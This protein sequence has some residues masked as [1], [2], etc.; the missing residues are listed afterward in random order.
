MFRQ[1]IK[2]IENHKKMVWRNRR[3]GSPKP[4]F[5][6]H[7]AIESIPTNGKKTLKKSFVGLS[8]SH[9]FGFAGLVNS[10]IGPTLTLLSDD[11]RVESFR[12]RKNF[13]FNMGKLTNFWC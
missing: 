1:T 4:L 3:F 10:K 2:I 8:N 6:V 11:D 5:L 7:E 12:N 9:L 13:N